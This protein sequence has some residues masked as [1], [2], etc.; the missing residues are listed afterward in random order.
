MKAHRFNNNKTYEFEHDHKEQYIIFFFRFYISLCRGQFMFS[1]KL[2][3]ICCS[4]RP[5]F[6]FQTESAL[7]Y[8]QQKGKRLKKRAAHKFSIWTSET[9]ND[10]KRNRSQRRSY[11]FFKNGQI[12][13]VRKLYI[14]ITKVK[15]TTCVPTSLQGCKRTYY[16]YN[17]R[18]QGNT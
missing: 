3:L 10:F 6:W 16:A 12:V 18:A 14:T 7:M 17:Y 8:K 15:L 11:H 1:P 5:A 13:R 4:S 9:I 2:T